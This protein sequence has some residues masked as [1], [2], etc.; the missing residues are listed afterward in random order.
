MATGEIRVPNDGALSVLGEWLAIPAGPALAHLYDNNVIFDRTKV[1]ADYNEASFVG[2]SSVGPLSWPAP[3]INLDGKAESDSGPLAWN[4]AAGSGTAIVF[5]I[6]FTDDPP[7]KL[8]LVVPFDTAVTLTPAMPNLTQAVQV[9][10]YGE[11]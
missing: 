8:L 2:Y 5:G 7:T 3:S 6:Y 1:L 4:F 11:F 10:E 9:T